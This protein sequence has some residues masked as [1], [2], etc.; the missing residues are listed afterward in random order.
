MIKYSDAYTER[1]KRLLPS[2]WEDFLRAAACPPSLR[3][4][5]L[6]MSAS[7]LAELLDAPLAP[8]PWCKDG[9]YF[10]ERFAAGKTTLHEAGAYYIQEASAML[11]AALL[12][13][14]PG[15]LVLDLCAAPGGKSTQ[16]A[17][18]MKGEGLLVCNEVVPSRA[19]I[20]SRNIERLGVRNAL[21]LN[22]SVPRLEKNFPSAFD[23]IL[24]DAPCSG[25]GMFVKSPEAMAEWSQDAPAICASRQKAILGSAA[26]MLKAG[27][28]LVYSTCTFAPEEN[29]LQ[30][31]RFLLDHPDFELVGAKTEI[32]QP[33]LADFVPDEIANKCVR[34]MPHLVKG[35]GH[36]CALLRKT[37]GN[38]I[39]LPRPRYSVPRAMASVWNDFCETAL[40]TRVDPNAAFGDSLVALPNGCPDLTGLKILRAGLRLGEVVKGRFIPSHSLAAA[41]SPQDAASVLDLPSEGDE[42]RGYLFGATLSGDVRGWTL[43]A[44][45]GCS[46]GWGKGS[47]GMIKNHYPKGLRPTR[48]H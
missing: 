21:V 2:E 19:A 27:G 6:K 1:I 40:K 48:S 42:T 29:E 30:I 3:V 10:P 26:N 36:F 33:H 43:I 37:D 9:Y 23:K 8:V 28:T 45:D 41:L 12:D 11:P 16:L 4:N 35:N 32:P 44:A 39:A 22:E 46:L 25:E 34:L 24:V 14:Q 7:H 15:E 18:A 17:A 20:L 47:D 5:T 31:E 38:D 13:A